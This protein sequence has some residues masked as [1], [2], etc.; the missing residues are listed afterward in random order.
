MLL[1]SFYLVNK[2]VMDTPTSTASANLGSS[3]ES[4]NQF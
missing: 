4:N 2:L 3:T 1:G